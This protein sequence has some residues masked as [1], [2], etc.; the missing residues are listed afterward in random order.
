MPKYQKG[1]SGNPSGRPRGARNKR[2]VAVEKLFTEKAEDLTKVAIKLAEAENIDALRMCMDRVYPKGRERPTPFELP[3]I[4]APKD[5][6]VAVSTIVQAVADGDLTTAEAAELIKVV[7]GFS[8]TVWD[9]DVAQRL[10]RI[11]EKLNES[12]KA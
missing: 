3:Q 2:T 10:K 4:A 6:V 7:Q 11:E 9:A 8:Q 12:K 1:Q 5:A